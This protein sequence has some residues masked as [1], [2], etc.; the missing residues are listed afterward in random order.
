MAKTVLRKAKDSPYVQRQNT[1]LRQGLRERS[2]S[3]STPLCIVGGLLCAGI[4]PHDQGGA[5]WRDKQVSSQA[6]GRVF[7][8][9][10]RDQR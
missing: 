5:T 2:L 9:N 1:D 7:S 4:R 10:L 6:S 8:R 3:P